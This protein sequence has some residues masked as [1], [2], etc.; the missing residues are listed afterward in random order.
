MN[1][2]VLNFSLRLDLRSSNKHVALQNLSTYY[3]WKSIRKQYK[4]NKLKIIAPKW[5]DEF[6]LPDGSYSVS[7]VQDYIK[8]I[9]KKHETL[10]SVPPIFV[11]TNR[12]NNRLVFIYTNGIN[13][14]LV[15][16]IKGGYKLESQKPEIMKLFGSTKKLI[17]KKGENVSNIEVVEVVLVQCDLVDNQYQPKSEVLYTFTPNKSYVYFLDAGPNNLV[18]L[19]TCN[20]KFHEITITFIDQNGRPLEEIEDKVTLTLLINKQNWHNILKNQEQ[21]NVKGIGV[22]SF[23]RNLSNKYKKELLNIGLDALKSASKTVVHK[24]VEATGELLGNKIACTVAKSNKDKIVKY[25][26]NPRNVEKV[27]IPPEKREEILTEL[28][29]V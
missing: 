28:R 14:R 11:D 5:N 23:A 20:T 19:K 26:E 18:F 13:N 21:E 25:D 27:I 22:L 29:Q 4:K 12:M 7:D 9:I 17:H 10:I 24:A 15:L 1:H 8:Y 6:E 16:K 2:F 3:M